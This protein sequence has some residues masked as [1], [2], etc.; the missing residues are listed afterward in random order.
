MSMGTGEDHSQNRPYRLREG[1]FYEVTKGKYRGRI[2]TC[3][4]PILV[5]CIKAI[6]RRQW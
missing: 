2:L 4:W 3:L 1:G 6:S 5:M